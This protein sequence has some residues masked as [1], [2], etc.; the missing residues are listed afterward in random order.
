MSDSKA[1]LIAAQGSGSVFFTCYF[2][3]KMEKIMETSD[4]DQKNMKRKIEKKIDAKGMQ[5]IHFFQSVICFNK[6]IF[7][8]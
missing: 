7:L 8:K 3:R 4:Y 1:F 5:N 6:Y 2:L